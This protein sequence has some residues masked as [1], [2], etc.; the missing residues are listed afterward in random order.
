LWTTAYALLDFK[1][2]RRKFYFMQDDEA[3]F[4]PAGSTSALVEATYGFGFHAICN[5][6]SLLRR[7]EARGGSGEYFIPNIDESVFHAAGRPP[8]RSKPPY[9]VFCYTRP[10]HPRNSFELMAETLR[11][12]KQRMGNDVQIITAGEEW[13]AAAYGLSNTVLNLGL[14]NYETTGA[15]YRACDAGIVLMMT[16]HPSYL[17]L[18][19]MACGALVVTNRNPDTGWL[20]KDEENCLL[21]EPT[22]TAIA[23]AVEKGLRDSELRRRITANARDRVTAGHADWDAAVERIHQFMR[24]VC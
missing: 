20:L 3:L 21:A 17:P 8:V 18:E 9:T 2:A 6:V 10:H 22:P 16:R 14:L 23:E 4:Y 19:L 15:L 13:D 24:N 1:K 7:Y 12:L 11:K 5:T